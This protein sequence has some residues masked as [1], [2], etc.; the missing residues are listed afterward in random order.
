MVDNGTVLEWLKIQQSSRAVS[1]AVLHHATITKYLGLKGTVNG[2]QWMS[3]NKTVC[4]SMGT[5]PGDGLRLEMDYFS[6]RLE[7]GRHDTRAPLS[8]FKFQ[9]RSPSTVLPVRLEVSTEPI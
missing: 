1:T 5:A 2:C 3:M 9:I 6:P 7:V 8:P 4:L